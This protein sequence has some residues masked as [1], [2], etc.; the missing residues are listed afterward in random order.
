VHVLSFEIIEGRTVDFF[1]TIVIA[2]VLI[3]LVLV[4][5]N[6]DIHAINIQNN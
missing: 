3:I 5:E 1:D 6:A 2:V 4:V